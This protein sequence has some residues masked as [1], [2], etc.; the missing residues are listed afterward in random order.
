MLEEQEEEPG[1]LEE[2][3]GLPEE[4]VDPE[5]DQEEEE[6]G[7]EE[8]EV[9]QEEEQEED[10]EEDQEELEEPEEPDFHQHPQSHLDLEQEPCLLESS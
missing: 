2:L 1:E 9:V 6:E 8:E 3:E 10:Q 7:E 5:V 4:A